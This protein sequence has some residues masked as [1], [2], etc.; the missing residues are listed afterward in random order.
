MYLESGNLE[1]R[2]VGKR[3]IVEGDSGVDPQGPR[4]VQADRLVGDDL[5]VEPATV[6]LVHTL[7]STTFIKLFSKIIFFVKLERI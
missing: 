3:H 6:L 7:L 1:E 5:V 2:Q 4:L